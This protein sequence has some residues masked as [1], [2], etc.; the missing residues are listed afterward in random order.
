MRF[1][2]LRFLADL[3]MPAAQGVVLKVTHVSGGLQD[4]LDSIHSADSHSA[5]SRALARMR[6]YLLTDRLALKLGSDSSKRILR[7]LG[8]RPAIER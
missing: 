5:V 4:C 1:L 7:T 2:F 3:K 8:W 6:F